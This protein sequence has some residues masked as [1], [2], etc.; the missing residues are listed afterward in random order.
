VTK[1]NMQPAPEVPPAEPV[2]VASVN[3]TADNDPPQQEQAPLDPK[4]EARRRS[5][6]DLER[7]RRMQRGNRR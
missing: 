1:K 4:E 7:K 5:R 3:A 6:E 2:D